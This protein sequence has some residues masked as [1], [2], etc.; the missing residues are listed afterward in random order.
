VP[1]GAEEWSLLP[2][3]WRDHYPKEKKSVLDNLKGAAAPL[4]IFVPLVVAGVLIAL[5]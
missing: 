5:G 1:G 4:E 3:E 2:L